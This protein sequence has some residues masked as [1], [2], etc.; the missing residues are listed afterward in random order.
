MHCLHC[1]DELQTDIL[2]TKCNSPRNVYLKGTNMFNRP[3]S[4]FYYHTTKTYSVQFYNVNSV[5][6]DYAVGAT[7]CITETVQGQNLSAI[8]NY[9]VF[10][11]HLHRIDKFVGPVGLHATRKAAVDH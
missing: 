6:S 10:S 8:C 11:F 5:G 3:I 2:F 1:L 4:G 7:Y 9:R